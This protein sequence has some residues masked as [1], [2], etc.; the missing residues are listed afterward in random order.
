MGKPCCGAKADPRPLNSV[1]QVAPVRLLLELKCKKG[2]ERG[3]RREGGR[4][5]RENSKVTESMVV[6]ERELTAY[7]RHP[8]VGPR[9]H[10]VALVPAVVSA[11]PDASG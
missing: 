11:D 10:H 5:T 4:Y 3:G 8:F 9:S 6:E 7:G 1:R 2:F